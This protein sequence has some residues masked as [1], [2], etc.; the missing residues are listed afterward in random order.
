MNKFFSPRMPTAPVD[1][2]QTRATVLSAPAGVRF[3]PGEKVLLTSVTLPRM[4]ARQRLAAA[5]F[6]AEDRIA[7]P[8]EDVH[9]A[10]G[11]E[12]S[13]NQ[14][15]VAVIAQADLPADLKPGQRILPDTLAVP[16]PSPG[17]WAVVEEAG[18]VLI[19]LP[20]GSGLVTG[21][22][23]LPILHE[24]A[25]LP[26][27]TLFAGQIALAHA[28]APLPPVTLP[29]RFDLCNHRQSL[30]MPPLARRL[31][32]VAGVAVLGHLAILA[33]DTVL[34]TR[35]QAYLASQLRSAAGSTADADTDSLLTRI[36]SPKVAPT[37][38]FLDLISASFAA[39]TAEP[40]RVSLRELRYG[41]QTNSLTL[42]LLAPDLTSLNQVEA[43][44]SAANLA[45]T[46][47][48]AT[49]A[50]GT[51]EQELTVRGPGT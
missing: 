50:N 6:A 32:T 25:G 1:P 39:L 9:V 3:I 27:I 51:A 34:L 29:A 33:A 12:T 42:T 24:L 19:R 17:T 48:P 7:R 37:A 16:V 45:V 18:R 26:P 14:W 40:G 11:P 8:L 20:D 49:T 38:G 5:T 30:A 2:Y 43:D 10:L 21:P 31:L 46:A 41:A 4:P 13:A 15:L 36:L 35:Q 44:L 22:A 28:A 47:G 23:A